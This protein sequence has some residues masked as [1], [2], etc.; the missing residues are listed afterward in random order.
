MKNKQI[1]NSLSNGS[2][3]Y[4]IRKR[5]IEIREVERDINNALKLEDKGFIAGGI[6]DRL[7]KLVKRLDELMSAQGARHM[8]LTVDKVRALYSKKKN[9]RGN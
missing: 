2:I 9:G 7:E 1:Q 5:Q 6:D 8:E 4:Q 3:T